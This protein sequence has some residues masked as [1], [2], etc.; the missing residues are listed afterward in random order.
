[1]FA[2]HGAVL[3]SIIFMEPLSYVI[4]IPPPYWKYSTYQDLAIQCGLQ[5][6][7]DVTFGDYPS[8]NPLSLYKVYSD[9]KCKW[10]QQRDVDFVVP[11]S[12]LIHDIRIA[13]HHV[14]KFK[15]GLSID[16]N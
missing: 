8:C 3:I 10:T 2:V 6:S 1:M 7:S 16:S 4:E 13:I 11:S 5:Y 9:R 14:L 12:L 15:Y